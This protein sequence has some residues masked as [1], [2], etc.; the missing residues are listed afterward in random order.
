MILIFESSSGK[1]G[2]VEMAKIK[3]H[4]ELTLFDDHGLA[5]LPNH[6]LEKSRGYY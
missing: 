6:K 5:S 1:G 4:T 2:K 3:V